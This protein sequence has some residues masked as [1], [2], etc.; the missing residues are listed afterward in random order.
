MDM[1]YT[2]SRDHFLI[3]GTPD[4]LDATIGWY[5]SKLGRPTQPKGDV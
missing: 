3:A 5:S 4:D 1:T 2:F